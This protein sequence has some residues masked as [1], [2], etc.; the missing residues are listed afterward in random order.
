M[1][2]E[3][4]RVLTASQIVALKIIAACLFLV[5][6]F[7]RSTGMKSCFFY[8]GSFQTNTIWLFRFLFEDD[9]SF[10]SIKNLEGRKSF[11]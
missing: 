8:P 4:V 1:D 7:S 5:L 9:A 6:P 10:P 2:A 3:R 11:W